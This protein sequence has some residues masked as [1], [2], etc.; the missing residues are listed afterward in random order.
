MERALGEALLFDATDDRFLHPTLSAAQA[1]TLEAAAATSNGS[2][3]KSAGAAIVADTVSSNS[4]EGAGLRGSAASGV[5]SNSSAGASLREVACLDGAAHSGDLHSGG[6]GA[7]GGGGNGRRRPVVA[8]EWSPHRSDVLAISLGAP[9]AAASSEDM[10]S[11]DASF[12]PTVGTLGGALMCLKQAYGIT[13]VFAG[14]F[15]FPRIVLNCNR[16]PSY[17]MKINTGSHSTD[18]AG[19]VQLWSLS[20][21]G[22]PERVLA[23]HSPILCL[24]FVPSNPHLICGGTYAGQVSFKRYERSLL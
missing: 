17:H 8:L 10:F 18:V 7:G 15:A 11:H 9:A 24:C 20:L 16:L 21:L 2:G 4:L 1:L 3:D 5:S 13:V 19:V 22:R 23:A 14:A 12:R 6:P